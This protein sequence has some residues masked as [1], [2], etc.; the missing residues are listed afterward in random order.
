MMWRHLLALDPDLPMVRDPRAF[1]R[2]HVEQFLRGA[3]VPDPAPARR[4]RA[5]RTP[6]PRPNSARRPSVRSRT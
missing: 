2:H 4:T 1:A 3:A 5:R 6:R